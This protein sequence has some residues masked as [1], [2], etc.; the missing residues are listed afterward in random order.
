MSGVWRADGRRDRSALKQLRA[1]LPFLELKLVGPEEFDDYVDIIFVTDR[2]G[3]PK[4]M[5]EVL[6]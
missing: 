6:L 4:G 5:V 1:G 3:V 2:M